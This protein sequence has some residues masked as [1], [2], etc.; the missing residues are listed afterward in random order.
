[1]TGARVHHP[2]PG[3]FRVDPD[4]LRTHA[5]Q[6]DGHAAR[7]TEIATAAQPLGLQAY[8]L[9]GQ[10]FAGTAR[11]TA[12]ACSAGVASL[13][14]LVQDFGDRLRRVAEEYRATDE[15]AAASFRGI[16]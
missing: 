2:D 13:A 10:A 6:V 7:V 16:R 9:V 12:Q 4:R 1:M 8:G 15:A 11:Q 3:G 5:T 14:A